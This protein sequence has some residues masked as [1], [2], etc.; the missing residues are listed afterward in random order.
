MDFGLGERDTHTEDRAFAVRR[1]ADSDQHGTVDD[2]P[3]VPDLF[4]ACVEDEIGDF[5]QRSIAP[6]LEFFVEKSCG[7]AD[8][9]AGDVESAEFFCDGGAFARGDALHVHFGDS[10]FQGPFAAFAPFE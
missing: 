8:L 10:Q 9:A 6:L 7:A 1:N 5:S 2:T 4:V 3:T